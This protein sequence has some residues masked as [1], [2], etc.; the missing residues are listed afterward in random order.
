MVSYS[1]IILIFFCVFWLIILLSNAFIHLILLCTPSW[2]LLR[3]TLQMSITWIFVMWEL[4]EA[5]AKLD[6]L[7]ERIPSAKAWDVTQHCT[8]FLYV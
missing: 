4:C 2:F 1:L 6:S 7:V 5:W 3:R 8:L